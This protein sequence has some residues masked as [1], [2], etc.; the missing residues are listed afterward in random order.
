MDLR[1]LPLAFRRHRLPA[2]LAKPITSTLAA[3][4]PPVDQRPLFS[5]PNQT[6]RCFSHSADN[7]NC[8]SGNTSAVFFVTNNILWKR[9]QWEAFQAQQ[10]FPSIAMKYC[11]HSAHPAFWGLSNLAFL[12]GDRVLRALL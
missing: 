1:L 11:Q 2:P 9:R 7:E 4:P 5:S 8:R 12:G 6:K 10:A 3:A